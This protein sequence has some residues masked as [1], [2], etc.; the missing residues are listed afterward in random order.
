MYT[1]IKHLHSYLPYL[2]LGLLV[3]ASLIFVVKR[4]SDKSFTKSDK[5]LALV[6]LIL[7]HLQL[8]VGLVLYFMSPVVEAAFQSDAIM[9]NAQHRFYAVE[10]VSL[11]LLAIALIT[12]GYSRAKRK[13]E[14]RAKFQ[15]L[16][17]FYL[18]G[19]LLALLRIPWDV[20]PA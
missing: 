19:L 20:W 10:H 11:M 18:L 4:I 2:L 17:I 16:S 12:I 8:V 14:D 15:T 13:T 7:A 1:G 5:S 9:S 6:V 3:V